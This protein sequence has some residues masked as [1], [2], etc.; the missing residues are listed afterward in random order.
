MSGPRKTNKTAAEG[1][2]PETEPVAAAETAATRPSGSG[3][4]GS[5]R[6]SGHSRAGSD[7]PAALRARAAASGC[8]TAAPRCSCRSSSACGSGRS[9]RGCPGGCGHQWRRD[10]A[11]RRSSAV[12]GAAARRGRAAR[13]RGFVPAV[14]VPAGRVR[15]ALRSR[16]HRLRRCCSCSSDS[17]APRC[18][19]LAP[20]TRWCSCCWARSWPGRRLL[21]PVHAAPL[22]IVAVR[23]R[24]AVAAL[25]LDRRSARGCGLLGCLQGQGLTGPNLIHPR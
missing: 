16:R 13:L 17:S 18:R 15:G 6:A 3:C 2:V 22:R 21:L 19:A 23:L 8:S 12:R 14:R 10:A 5:S 20:G 11:S 1:G 24:L 9:A 25:L 7:G 4:R